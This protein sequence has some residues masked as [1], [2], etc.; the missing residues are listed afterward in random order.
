MSWVLTRMFCSGRPDTSASTVRMACGAW[1][2]MW[3]VS[4]P[5]TA[6]QSATQPHVSIDATWMRG[7]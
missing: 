3:S 6:F 5:R 2:V 1:L 7:M 4:W